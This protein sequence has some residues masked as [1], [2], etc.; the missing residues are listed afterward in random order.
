MENLNQDEKN[1]VTE[2]NESN[3]DDCSDIFVT[4][5]DTFDITVRY[6]NNNDELIVEN[7]DDSFDDTF[8]T[9]KS[10]KVTFKYPS[11]SDYQAIQSSISL[12][13]NQDL[14]L[15]DLNSLQDV[16]IA[17][18]FRS[19]TINSNITNIKDM[20]IKLVKAIRHLVSE[21]ISMDGIM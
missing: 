14:T 4:E 17:M 12:K 7:I 8:V 5:N 16:R 11:F 20:N 21:K 18:L 13:A 15:K 19:W 6:Y 1:V 9:V 3:V 2:A 10:F